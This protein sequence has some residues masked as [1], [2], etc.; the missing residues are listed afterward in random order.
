[1][2]VYHFTNPEAGGIIHEDC[3]MCNAWHDQSPLIFLILFLSLH[4]KRPA[5]RAFFGFC[6]AAMRRGVFAVP[7]RVRREPPHHAAEGSNAVRALGM[8]S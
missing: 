1:M 7:G 2:S 6:A 3:E 4:K 8:L 5:S